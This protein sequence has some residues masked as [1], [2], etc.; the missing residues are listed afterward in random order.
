MK[1]INNSDVTFKDIKKLKIGDF[2]D[3]IQYNPLNKSQKSK[4][5]EVVADRDTAAMYTITLKEYNLIKNFIDSKKN[6][7]KQFDKLNW[8]GHPKSYQFATIIDNVSQ[9]VWDRSR[10]YE[11]EHRHLWSDVNMKIIKIYKN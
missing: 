6:F 8:V 7:I 5:K 2:I 4:I 3:T 9:W 1:K 10:W 11:N